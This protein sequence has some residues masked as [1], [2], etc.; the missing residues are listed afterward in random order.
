MNYD[1]G[2]GVGG[3]LFEFLECILRAKTILER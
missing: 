3:L 2:S 1:L